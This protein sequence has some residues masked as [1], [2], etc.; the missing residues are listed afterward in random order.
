MADGSRLSPREIDVRSLLRLNNTLQVLTNGAWYVA[1]PFIPLYL[2]AQGASAGVVGIVVGCSGIAP[3]LV[4]I[5]A[6]AL[7][8]ERGP[9]VVTKISVFLFAAAGVILTIGHGIWPTA[10][11]YALMAVANIGFA[12]APQAIVAA[13]STD[14]TRIRN[15]GYY[16]L[17]NSAGAVAGPILG[18]L[19]AG[20]FGY[21]A[22]FS[23]VWI[24]MLPSFAVAASLHRAPKAPRHA[25]SIA[26]AHTLVGTILR[27]R[28]V[29]AILFISGMMVCAQA[30]QQ[31]FFPLYLNTVGLPAPLIGLVVAAGSLGGM[32]VR[33]LL[34][35]GVSWLGY[36]GSLIYATGL[37]AIAFG[38]TPFLRGFWPLAC[39]SAFV[40]ANMGFTMPLSMSLLVES[41][42]AEFWGVALGIRQSV[43]RLGAIVSPFVFGFVSTA[44]GI[45]SAFYVGALAFVGAAAIMARVG[46]QIRRPEGAPPP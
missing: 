23:V 10:V 29:G 19:L 7:V 39:V 14:A 26:T 13:V 12:V 21:A 28:G 9:A 17:S 44:R 1:T 3:L 15:Y 31:S 18:G 34:A 40:G 8:D 37:V 36:S 6:G 16:S 46:G 45:E 11:A 38:V 20:R 33:T 24:M 30:L 2:V 25:V 35:S 43:Q 42:N 27:Q 5:H 41:V 32:A 22:A 4:S